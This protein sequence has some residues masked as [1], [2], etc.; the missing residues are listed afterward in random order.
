MY[1]FGLYCGLLSFVLCSCTLLLSVS[2][3]SQLDSFMG[4]CSNIGAPSGPVAILEILTPANLA[5]SKNSTLVIS[6]A[7]GYTLAVSVD[8]MV[9]GCTIVE[10]VSAAGVTHQ[11]GNTAAIEQLLPYFTSKLRV[12][13]ITTYSV[14]TEVGPSVGGVCRNTSA[15]FDPWTGEGSPIGSLSSKVQG[16]TITTPVIGEATIVGHSVSV[17]KS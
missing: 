17:P 7:V 1:S 9:L 12:A 3:Q 16:M 13:G 2:L 10:T 15:V 4:N 11:P 8:G 5:I 14:L 6:S